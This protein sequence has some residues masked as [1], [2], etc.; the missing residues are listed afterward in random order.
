VVDGTRVVAVQVVINHVVKALVG[1]VNVI[2]NIV[3]DVVVIHVVAIY[4]CCCF[5]RYSH[6][7]RC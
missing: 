7:C 1:I 5:L 2:D 6:V 3:E 4:T